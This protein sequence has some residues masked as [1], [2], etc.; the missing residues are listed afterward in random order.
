MT[1][2]SIRAQ[3]AAGKSAFFA[4]ATDRHPQGESGKRWLLPPENDRRCWDT[5]TAAWEYGE[6]F[7]L[8]GH[9]WERPL[10]HMPMFKSRRKKAA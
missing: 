4:G 8:S 2:E 7:N 9:G 10:L 1:L 6:Y 5:S 3:E